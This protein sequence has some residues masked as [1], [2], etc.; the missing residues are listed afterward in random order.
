MS[1]ASGRYN[2]RVDWLNDCVSKEPA[3]AELFLVQS[4]LAPVARVVRDRMTQAVLE[5]GATTVSVPGGQAE[6]LLIDDNF[7][8]IVASLGTGLCLWPGDEICF[9]LAGL[10]YGKVV[11]ACEP[12]SLGGHV[13]EHV[14]GLFHRFLGPLVE[15]GHVYL[16]VPRREV[17]FAA[18]VMDPATRSLV[19]LLPEGSE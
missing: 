16:A 9:S 7:Q 4:S 11:I 2:D 10:R 15:A 19:Q 14:V 5:I 3:V 13:T 18:G 8:W 6:E 17:E 1:A 12:T